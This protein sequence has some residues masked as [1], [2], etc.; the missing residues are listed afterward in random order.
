MGEVCSEI[1]KHLNIE[2]ITTTHNSQCNGALERWHGCF[3]GMLW[4]LE[5]KLEQWDLLL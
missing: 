4:K 5:G 1:C 2:H 3:K